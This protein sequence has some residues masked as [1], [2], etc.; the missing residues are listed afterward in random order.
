VTLYIVIFLLVLLIPVVLGIAY[1]AKRMSVKREAVRGRTE[2][3]KNGTPVTLDR[4]PEMPKM[5]GATS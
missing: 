3:P 5:P 4:N 1:F 2:E